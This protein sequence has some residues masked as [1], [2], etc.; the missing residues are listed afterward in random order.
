MKSINNK[1]QILEDGLDILELTMNHGLNFFNY[2]S[3]RFL[4]ELLEVIDLKDGDIFYDIGSGYGIVIAELAKKFPQTKFIGIEIV[5]ERANFSSELMCK[6]GLDNVTIINANFLDVDFSNGNQFFIFNPIYDFQYTH[7][8]EKLE[9]INHPIIAIT[10]SKAC[11]HFDRSDSF[12][13]IE[14]IASD[15]F[16]SLRVF[17]NYHQQCV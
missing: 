1:I 9:A 15:H 13:L 10:E 6:N 16:S 12:D 7:L 5:K 2:E 8:L 14:E 11:L 4:K 3:S 17:K